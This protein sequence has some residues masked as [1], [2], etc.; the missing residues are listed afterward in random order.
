MPFTQRHWIRRYAF[1]ELLTFEWN[2]HVLCVGHAWIGSDIVFK[3]SKWHCTNNKI[4]WWPKWC[5]ANDKQ[6]IVKTIKAGGINP[7]RF[8]I[9]F[10]CLHGKMFLSNVSN[11][12]PIGPVMG[13]ISYICSGVVRNHVLNCQLGIYFRFILLFKINC[14]LSL[15]LVCVHLPIFMTKYWK[16]NKTSMGIVPEGNHSHPGP[17]WLVDA[18]HFEKHLQDRPFAFES[19]TIK[20]LYWDRTQETKT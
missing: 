20:I 19:T 5:R 1:P 7:H 11:Y 6:F 15:R 18:S 14:G 3:R 4:K 16:R 17:H 12:P 8:G 13:H 10:L 9:W 2:Q